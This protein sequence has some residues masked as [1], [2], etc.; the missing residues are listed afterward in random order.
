MHTQLER[1]RDQNNECF[2]LLMRTH[3]CLLENMSVVMYLLS[4]TVQT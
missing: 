1:A 4:S 2:T 3:L